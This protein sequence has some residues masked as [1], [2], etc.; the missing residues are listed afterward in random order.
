MTCA[1]RCL[2]GLFG[3][4][5]NLR[6]VRHIFFIEGILFIVLA[7]PAATY[8]GISGLLI[9]SLA[10]HLAVTCSLSIWAY[11]GI[12]GPVRPI[13]HCVLTSMAV[14]AL[15]AVISFFFVIPPNHMLPNF[16]RFNALITLTILTG[17]FFIFTSS[18]R[19]ELRAKFITIL[20][21]LHKTILSR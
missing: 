9:V 11:K 8:F 6:P 10:A 20:S 19:D 7:F 1:T 14:A 18:L 2:T 15:V 4:I 3:I 5:G 17:W 16:L 12:V 21:V 13:I